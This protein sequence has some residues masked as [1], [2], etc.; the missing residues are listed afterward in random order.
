ML[1]FPGSIARR[2]GIL[3]FLRA[4]FQLVSE[5]GDFFSDQVVVV[6]A[7]RIS[8]DIR[9]LVLS[10]VTRIRKI[11]S[12]ETIFVFDRFLADKEFVSFISA[13]DV[14]CMPYIK[15]IGMSGVLVQ[16]AACGKPVLAPEF[17]LIGELVRRYELGILC[18]PTDHENLVA[19]L[20]ECL[21]QVQTFSGRQHKKLRLFAE[22]HSLERLGREIC[23]SMMRTA[24]AG[25]L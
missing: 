7:G 16:A 23:D 8:S 13:S 6:I 12:E 22:G 25:E 18:R 4:L 24:K 17:G 11:S 3:E 15:F 21:E 2:K 20:Y 10:W 14:V 1:L 19:A 9:E 5:Q